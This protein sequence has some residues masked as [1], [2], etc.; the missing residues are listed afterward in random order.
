MTLHLT[1]LTSLLTRRSAHEAAEAAAFE[2]E[3]SDAAPQRGDMVSLRG[4]YADYYGEVI[5]TNALG[6]THLYF[7]DPS[8][9][10]WRALWVDTDRLTV[11]IP[12]GALTVWAKFPV[13]VQ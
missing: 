10:E 12:G 2:I 8:F 11:L 7:Y 1:S 3:N 13:E 6:R 9:R 4:T 5:Q